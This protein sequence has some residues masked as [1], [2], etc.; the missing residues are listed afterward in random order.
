MNLRSATIPCMVQILI[1]CKETQLFTG[2]NSRLTEVFHKLLSEPYS[3]SNDFKLRGVIISQISTAVVALSVGA[4]ELVR[5]CLPAIGQIMLNCCLEFK[6]VIIGHKQ[7]P[8]D[9]N[10]TEP[11]NFNQ[12]IVNILDLIN[13]IFEVPNVSSLLSDGLNE[14]LY[15]LL[16]LMCN[17]E[18]GD[19]TLFED[20]QS[21]NTNFG[22]TFRGRCSFTFMV[23]SRFLFSRITVFFTGFYE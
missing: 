23:L 16:L 8:R 4:L 7:M 20:S 21:L 14:F 17:Y 5:H 9:A 1:S 2:T 6:E 19:E 3:H 12:L 11:N 13:N 10:E 15:L 22:L 18:N